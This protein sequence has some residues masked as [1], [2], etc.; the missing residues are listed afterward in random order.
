[1]K[2]I[3]WVN[4]SMNTI[5]PPLIT[6]N[7]QR[8][9]EKR[10]LK[11]VNDRYET[12]D[13]M[14]RRVAKRVASAES[15][16]SSGPETQIMEQDFF[17]AMAALEFLPNSPTL[18]NSDLDG[19]IASCFVLP[20][21]DSIDEIF[22]AVKNTAR[23]HQSCGGTGFSFSRIRPE[24]DVVHDQPGIAPGPV[25]FI[26][27]FSLASNLVK[28]GGVRQGCNIGI[29][30]VDHPDI[31]KFIAMKDDPEYLTNFC[32]S[33]AITDKFLDALFTGGD[34]DL[35]NPRTGQI[36]GY[37]NAQF[38][39]DKITNQSWK[40]G[41][42]GLIFIDRINRDQPTPILGKIEAVT[43]CAEQVLLPFECCH[44]GSINLAKM[45]K[46]STD[47]T[48]V[49]DYPKIART[50]RL[51]IRFLDDCIDINNYPLPQIEEA[52]KRTRKIGLSVMGYADMLVMLEIPYDSDLA[53]ETANKI[54]R[55]IDDEAH[56]ASQELAQKRGVFPAY[57][58]SKY[59]RPNGQRLRNASCTM[60][61]P[62]GSL[63]LI[64]G[65]N[66]GIEP[67]FSMVFV[68]NILDGEH[69]LEVNP[70]FETYARENGFFSED[71]LYRLV[72]GENL[73][74][75]PGIPEAAKRIFVTTN[76]V[77]PEWHVR[78]QGVFQKNIDGAIAKMINVPASTT[79]QEIGEIFLM[80]YR[81]GVKGVTAYRDTSRKIQSLCNDENGCDL[82]R[83]YMRKL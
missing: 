56:I 66:N 61:A 55:L 7:G 54:M 79:P 72:Q 67:F 40:T 73:R 71:L 77:K 82:V 10:Y 39:F 8:V 35:I 34:Y 19:Q 63:S 22:E 1:M 78:T 6:K 21:G 26:Q 2:K 37:L 15:L 33:V 27:A 30:N 48:L 23:V 62:T 25:P 17:R 76:Q 29:L 64:A 49:I 16:Y 75:V 58:G 44:L 32:I 38:V 20:V 68:R 9:L 13:S 12:I 65:C 52:T 28:Q 45:L 18:L 51:G 60:I 3:A 5:V 31:L 74:D 41:D 83:D 47:G 14:F 42:P 11:R 4:D 57:S 24:G 81:E 69:L 59:D 70:Y 36:Q 53:L 80:A 46:N 50:A 43:S